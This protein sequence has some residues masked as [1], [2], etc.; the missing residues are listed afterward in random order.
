MNSGSQ[1]VPTLDMS[2]D[3][4]VKQR[5][6]DIGRLV[7]LPPTTFRLLSLLMSEK[8][9]ARELQGVLEQDPGLAAKVISLSN[10][11]MYAVRDSIST[12]DRAITIIGFKELEII[13]L[14][15]G[16]TETFDLKKVPPGFDGR[17]LWLHCLAVSWIARELVLA[18]WPRQTQEASEAMIGGL[19]HELGIIIL[20][21][22]F[23]VHFQQLLD[24]VN[25]G[26]DLR[27]AEETLGLRHEV[28]GCL[29]AKNWDL[30]Q[31]FQDVILYHHVPQAA[32]KS[33]RAVALITLADNLAFRTGYGVSI[34]NVQID[35]PYI[36]NVLDLSVDRLQDLVK[37][38]L[39]SITKVQPLWDQVMNGKSRRQ[40]EN[41]T[42]LSSLLKK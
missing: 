21:A 3:L 25:S 41:S 10:S 32:K 34:E 7:S 16:L 39:T 42:S 30:P 40:E 38:I 24:L 23:P 5:L 2:V 15:I 33:Q 20:I 4:Q 31:V 11:A 17:G 29:L 18:L 27:Q 9:S 36:L 22:K 35:L 12:I 28:V 19:L 13:A 6:A 1:T 8:T 26:Q 37:K 14:G